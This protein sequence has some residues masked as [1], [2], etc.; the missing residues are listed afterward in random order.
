MLHDLF[1]FR[2]LFDASLHHN[3]LTSSDSWPLINF[4]NPAFSSAN[5]TLFA[6]LYQFF[7]NRVSSVLLIPRVCLRN[8]ITRSELWAAFDA[9]HNYIAGIRFESFQSPIALSMAVVYLIRPELR[10]GIFLRDRL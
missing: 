4:V 5:A 7:H 8:M 10:A 6:A 9:K 2:E 1:A 3:D